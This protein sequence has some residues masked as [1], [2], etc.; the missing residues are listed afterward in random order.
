M[1]MWKITR[2]SFANLRRHK[3][4]SVLLVLLI[5]ICMCM[6]GAA[7]GSMQEIGNIFPNALN[8]IHGVENYIEMPKNQFQPEFMRFLEEQDGVTQYG[9]TEGI[10]TVNG[11]FLNQNG[12]ELA[13]DH[14]F[15]SHENNL[16]LE[17][18][19]LNS[20]FSESEIAAIAHP[21]WLPY[22][23][24]DSFHFREGDTYTIIIAGR[25]YPFQ[26]IGFY[27]SG[28]HMDAANGFKAIISD[29][30]YK[31]MSQINKPCAFIYYNTA[32]GTDTA[33][34]A[35][36]FL[37]KCEDYSHQD[38]HLCYTIFYENR[39]ASASEEV[40]L[41]LYLL[42][43]MSVLILVTILF[44][45]RYRISTD[46]EEQIV[47]I[48][49]L[50]ALGYQ[51]S[52]INAMFTIE[53]LLL[54]AAG[55]LI[56]TA[57]AAAL[58]PLLYHISE[59]TSGH[60]GTMHW[61]FGMLL[62]SACIVFIFVL[63]IAFLRAHMIHRYPPVQALRKGIRDHHYGKNYF[64]LHK[65]KH[66]LHL[67]LAMKGFVQDVRKNI[68]V[69]I[70][71]MLASLTFVFCALLLNYATH[72][73]EFLRS[74]LGI[75]FSDVVLTLNPGAD[76]D[77]LSD[78]LHNDPDVRKVLQAGSDILPLKLVEQ[79][80]QLVPN[81]YDDY[82]QLEY[83]QVAEGRFP[84]HE[85]EVM[86]T[87]VQKKMYHLQVG[88]TVHLTNGIVEKEYVVTGFYVGIVTGEACITGAG[89]QRLDPTFRNEYI[90]LYLNQD[91]DREAFVKKLFAKYGQSASDSPDGTNSGD[92][93]L[94][95]R[96]RLAAQQKIAA[97]IQQYD[98][99]HVDYAITVD[100]QVISGNSSYFQIHFADATI[101]FITIVNSSITLSCKAISLIFTLAAA[102]I[103]IA[104]VFVLTKTAVKKQWIA[105]GIMKSM[106]YT[107]KML[108]E[109]IFLRILPTVIIALILG[110]AL[111]IICIRML[112]NLIGAVIISLPMIVFAD[113][114]VLLLA[115]AG[116]YWSAR[117][118]RSI[119][120]R[121]LMTE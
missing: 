107:T 8:E 33:A 86:F 14:V 114:A 20:P 81:I 35:D 57:G 73:V 58:I 89:Y 71:I 116:T 105:F 50:E 93:S 42:I 100:D 56:G 97:M 59:V 99:S 104:T 23:L 79:N 39:V 109:Q 22:M 113:A 78:A 3:A 12:K 40:K 92:G 1:N 18:P 64:P 45:I 118:I 29:A 48:G 119:S 60:H 19:P 83:M 55:I 7:L 98:V 15:I 87:A 31:L 103:V 30:D 67:R 84:Q 36:T 51:F 11:R 26:I 96:I 65:T 21:I 76:I 2:L 115:C 108:I 43:I 69:G 9:Y 46:I 75:E 61:H 110:N 54:A 66:N 82:S 10:F 121:E 24:K 38:L 95:E 90:Y 5:A 52:D 85:N 34:V 80:E 16:K 77:R 49:V 70:S 32:A 6:L 13:V 63:L 120:V 47:S 102:L 111:S 72:E 94:E 101:D 88:D 68:G 27:E 41:I 25:A 117:K 53:Y 91:V 28:M 17:Q 74:V 106:G 62:L 4:E 112:R 44:V 37:E